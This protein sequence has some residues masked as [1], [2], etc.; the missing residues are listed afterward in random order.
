VLC[1]FSAL[2]HLEER[3]DL[4]KVF[5]SVA[6]ALAPGGLFLFDVDTPRSV[7][8]NYA[9]VHFEDRPDFKLVMRGT[10]EDGGRRARLDLD[11]FLPEASRRSGGARFR[12][13]HDVLWNSCWRE[14][15]LRRALRRAGLRPLA[16]FDGIDV[17]PR[18]PGAERGNDLYLLAQKGTTRRKARAAPRTGRLT[19]GT[20]ARSRPS[21]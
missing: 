2:N 8:K 13:E 17:R 21:R 16:S 19:G 3:R 11:W 20:A 4:A 5:A 9:S 6:R 18:I 12:H 10:L 7:E 1:E 15:E 14:G